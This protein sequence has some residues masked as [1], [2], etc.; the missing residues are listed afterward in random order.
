MVD[1]IRIGGA[2]GYWGESAMATPQ[3]L[4]DRSVDFLVYDYLA[5]ITMSIMS[6]ARASDPAMGY[7]TDFI[8]TVLKP[9]IRDIAAQGV[10]VISNA[11][12]M[13]PQACAAA[14]RAVSDAA[15]LDLKIGVIRGDD[16]LAEKNRL[17]SAVPTEMFSG[18]AFPPLEKLVSINAY[19]GAFPIAA[20]LDAGADIVI[21]GRCVDSAVTLGACVHAFGWQP[22]DWNRLAA[23]SLAGH[24]L[25]CGPQA[26]GGNHT[27]WEDIAETIH[28]IGY[29]ICDIQR[30]GSFMVRKPK[31]TGGK[32]TIGTVAEQMLYEIG[33]PQ[34]YL[35][36]D[37][38]CDFST[39]ELNQISEDCV[40]VAGAT[41]FAAPSTYKSSITWAD[42]FRAGAYF[43][44]T[45]RDA[46][47]KATVFANAA[48]ARARAALRG[49]SMDDFTETSVEVLG[50]ES[51]YGDARKI[52]SA[53]EVV[54]K[55]AAK[56]PEAV[57]VDILLKEASGMGLATPSALSGFAGTRPKPSPVVRLFSFL[58]PKED[59]TLLVEVDG[60]PLE[61][62]EPV[63]QDDGRRP[64]RPEPP[65]IITNT[66]DMVMIRLEELAWGRSGDKGDKANIGIAARNATYLPWIWQ[67]LTEDAVAQYF[68]HF[69]TG[70]AGQSV[71]RFL[72]PGIN[73][74]NFLLHDVLG[75]GG[76]ASLRNDSQGKGYAQLLLDYT[77]PV[78]RDLALQAESGRE[79]RAA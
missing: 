58:V 45:G 56:H 1:M 36:P 60:Q 17:A 6:R 30:D 33:D 38:S 51:Q 23:G 29:P 77:I 35:L 22:S 13:N 57:G 40:R 8:S 28:A 43:T 19:I 24:V 7:A 48:L 15:G 66:E 11:G 62:A 16:L 5:E 74:I 41:G 26:T 49:R 73:A 72:L 78:P 79:E 42:G 61:Y 39:V 18:Q 44:F 21:T 71:E 10:K 75:G 52:G 76:I 4:A 46:D 34:A 27:D 20:A 65:F 25:E 31:G 54:L 12:G 59:V 50:A 55:L 9:N 37:V 2:S 14:V 69:L 47:R 67:A 68:A 63:T 3:L 64:C 70:A 32:V 53:R